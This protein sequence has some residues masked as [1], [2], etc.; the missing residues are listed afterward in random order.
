MEIIIG[1]IYEISREWQPYDED[2]INHRPAIVIQEEGNYAYIVLMD[3]F[4][5]SSNKDKMLHIAYSINN[6]KYFSAISCDVIHRIT[7]NLLGNNLG[8]VTD[9]IVKAIIECNGN[10]YVGAHYIKLNHKD[11]ANNII[12]DKIDNLLKNDKEQMMNV[13]SN[14]SQDT[15]TTRRI[16]E[17]KNKKINIWKERAVG[18][19]LGLI[20]S[21]LATISY[22]NR[23]II[24]DF[25][26]HILSK[27]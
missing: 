15:I 13:L 9:D 27:Q 14:I 17:D 20:A 19:I 16:T 6:K 24:I 11:N 18:F 23:L 12:Y 22:E 10:F 1:G 7:K 4:H 5:S 8:S 26:K 2:I 21:I 25:L 3:V